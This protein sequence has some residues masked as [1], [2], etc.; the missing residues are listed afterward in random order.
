MLHYPAPSIIAMAFF[1][2]LALGS[3]ATAAR[4]V[5]LRVASPEET[6]VAWQSDRCNDND[7]PDM[8][9]RMFRDDTGATRVVATH[10]ENRIMT[11]LPD[12][13]IEKGDC[14]IALASRND[15]VSANYAD[16]NWLSSVWSNGGRTVHAIVHHE[17]QAHLHAGA[18][19]VKD[20]VGCWF[21]TLTYARSDDGGLTFNQ[22]NPPAVIAS[23]PFTQDYG[24]GRH[25]GFFEPANIVKHGDFWLFLANT[26]GWPGQNAGYCLFR[27]SDIAD[28][29]SWRAWDGHDFNAS[30]PA[31]TAHEP[32]PGAPYCAPVFT[33]S[34][35]SVLWL[36]ESQLFLAAAV[37]QTANT[38]TATFAVVTSTS[39]DMIHW[40]PFQE[41]LP[42]T[43]GS[44]KSCNDTARYMYP[45]L[46]SHEEDA[47]NNKKQTLFLY[48]TRMNVH[49]C[50]TSSDRDLV[51][52]RIEQSEASSGPDVIKKLPAH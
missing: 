10:F 32:Q 8:P 47:A 19:S 42:V 23:A 14:H 18:C 24:Q 16:K 4:D 5:Q 36:E 33:A 13:R 40:G 6:L 30:F 2:I 20:Y 3:N 1:E 52:Y 9:V 49:N 28:P 31:P 37:Q 41:L 45:S 12:G 15:G 46:I 44:S 27:T 29:S 38:K 35:G 21:N 26:T 7:F 22:S 48:L 17:Y 50:K 43:H 11:L 51:R 34:L 25:R 39:P